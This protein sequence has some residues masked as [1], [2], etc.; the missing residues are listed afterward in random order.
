MAF[1]SPACS[2]PCEQSFPLLYKRSDKILTST[3]A[4]NRTL[5]SPLHSC[6]IARNHDNNT[7]NDKEI[8][9]EERAK[10]MAVEVFDYEVI[11]RHSVEQEALVALED[12]RDEECAS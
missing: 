10:F 3:I 4:P 2:R 8:A 7:S 12:A 11:A 9:E 1:S 5:S 6:A